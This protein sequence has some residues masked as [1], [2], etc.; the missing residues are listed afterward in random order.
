MVNCIEDNGTSVRYNTVKTGIGS[1]DTTICASGGDERLEKVCSP[2]VHS[3][4]LVSPEGKVHITPYTLCKRLGCFCVLRHLVTAMDRMQL[5]VLENSFVLQGVAQLFHLSQALYHSFLHDPSIM[6]CR[7]DNRSLLKVTNETRHQ[8]K[9]GAS[10]HFP[11][12][13]IT[14]EF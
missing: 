10:V 13:E 2:I 8:L 4:R 1:V 9:P 3:Q 11:V 5:V 12:T 7:R 14:K 6:I